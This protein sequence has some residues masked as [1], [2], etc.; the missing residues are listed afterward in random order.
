[1]KKHIYLLFVTFCLSF[2]HSMAIGQGLDNNKFFDGPHIFYSGDSL[3]IK[4]FDN[5]Y[6]RTFKIRQNG[7]TIFNGFLC[8]S[9]KSYCIPTQFHISPQIM[10]P[11][12][13]I[14][15]VSDIHGQF[16]IFRRLL[17]NN[18]IINNENL[19]IWG[20]GH[21]VILGDVFDRGD[22]VH[23]NL[24]LIHQLERQANE[25]G[26]KVHF[27]HGNHEAMVMQNDLR[28]VH[29][30]YFT[31]VDSFQI[32][33][34]ELYGENTFWG[35]WLRSKN[36]SIQIGS[37]LFVHGGIHP[38]LITKFNS[39]NDINSIMQA[40]LDM[41][42]DKIKNDPLLSLLFGSKGPIW[43]RGFFYPDSSPDVSTDELTSILNHFNAEKIIVGHTTGEHIYSSY[44]GRVI[45]V[46]GG[47]KDGI[48]GESLSI[49]N[50]KYYTADD[51]GKNE[52]LFK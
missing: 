38:E 2:Q 25:A 36:V 5:G 16:E 15:V 22:G 43:H 19:W 37:L 20:K 33:I 23:E 35:R 51:S 14:F 42:R 24:W 52:I 18:G 21:L 44:S 6:V 47:I 26:G 11:T 46:D 3:T 27:L 1:M 9:T 10:P 4:Y 8:D 30:K 39:I 12:D 48:R 32:S 29:D 45:C 17:F 13:K 7:I 31:I 28:Y 40:N 50:G 41:N 34:P 49:I